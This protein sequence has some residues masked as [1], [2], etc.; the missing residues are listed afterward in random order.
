MAVLVDTGILYA[1]ADKDDDWHGR[2]KQW[3]TATQELLLVPV[4]VLPETA[5]LISRRLGSK[6]EQVFISSLA[7]E[8]L[9]VEPLKRAD[10]SRSAALMTRFPDIGFVDA[11]V[12]AMAERLRLTTIATTDRRH[13]AAV[14][15]SHIA[16]FMLVP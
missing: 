13:F 4:V 7:A 6:A 5:Y 10:L 11:T 15:P 14:R 8:E 16:S 3:V 9:G 1:L 2:A 12:V